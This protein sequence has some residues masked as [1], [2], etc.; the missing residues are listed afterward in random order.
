M[1]MAIS[2]TRRE[3]FPEWYQEVIKAADLAEHAPVRGCMI[4]KPNGYAIWENIQSTL[5]KKFKEIGVQ[6]AYFPLFIPL[7]YIEK[8]ASH[9]EG[10]AKECAIVTHTRLEKG[11]DGKLT[12]TNQLEEPLIVRPTSEM[13]IGDSFAKWI[14]SY[15]DLPMK[16]NQ[17]CNVVRWEMRPRLFLRT[18]EF[19]WQEG[20]TAH[21]T[22]D[23]GEMQAR[24]MLDLYA[25]FARDILA[26]PVITGDKSEGERFPGAVNTLTFEGMMQDG[27]A[28]QMGTSH[29]MGTNFAKASGIQFLNESG[30][31]EYVNT[32]S[33]GVT[34]RMI[35]A[36]IMVHSDDNGF[37]MPPR[38][39]SK[40]VAIVPFLVKEEH[41]SEVLSYCH[42]LAEE[43]NKIIYYNK[44]V[45][46]FVDTTN[47]RGG[48]KKWDAIKKG[49]PLRLEIGKRDIEQNRLPLFLRTKEN[50]S[51]LLSKDELIKEIT[52]Y[53]DQIHDTL[54]QKAFKFQQ[55][56][57]V[58]VNS[59][60]EFADLF[61]EGDV[62][63]NHFVSAPFIGNKIVEGQIQKEYNVTIR[64]IPHDQPQLAQCI[65]TKN[66][67]A[68]HAIFAKAY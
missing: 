5:D 13:I 21:A 14:K 58:S 2:P 39:A 56:N 18:S 23:D 50:D 17:W 9:I 53:L 25:N 28:L 57:I 45:V 43:L 1:K 37:V 11:V 62:F 19:L 42:K 52:N 54:Y 33:W 47:R 8:E 40:H 59:L 3:D 44:S 55:E 35:G 63:P 46:A 61:R 29:F 27:K 60:T 16:V 38:V 32:T 20:H 64:C 30:N 24:G 22:S 10:F 66:S 4:I 34:T 36:I 49:Y 51:I 31:L 48:E 41:N 15:R 7:S 68:R 12:P 67:G 65:F 26:I 6:N